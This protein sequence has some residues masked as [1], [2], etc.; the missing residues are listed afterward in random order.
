MK[1]FSLAAAVWIAAPLSAQHVSVSAVA[2]DPS[3][4]ALVW[5]CN[6]DNHSVSVVDTSVGTAVE[7]P[8]GVHP[9]SLAFDAAGTRVFVAN[10][11]GNVP[12]ERNFVTPFDG[13]EQRGTISVVDVATRSVTTTMTNVGTEPYGVAVAPAG[14][15]FAVSGFCSGTIKFYDAATLAPLHTHQFAR[16]LSFLPPGVTIAEA[17]EDRD[18][19]ADLGDPRGFVIRADGARMYVTHHKSPWISV[20]DLELDAGGLVRGTVLAAK[21]D[22]NEYGLHPI[23]APVRVQD[24][25]SQGVPRFLEDIALSPDGTRALVPHVLHNTNHDVTHDFG[26]ELAGDFANRVYPALTLIDTVRDSFGEPGDASGRLHHELADDPDPAEFVPYGGS[27]VTRAGDRVVLGG[28]GSPVLGGSAD[29]VVSGMRPGDLAFLLIGHAEREQPFGSTGVLR[30]EPRFTLPMPGGAVSVALPDVPELEGFTGFAQA[31]LV[32]ASVPERRLSNGL[33]FH[34]DRA[35]FGRGK[36]GHRAGH[37][38]RV[39]FNAA[40]DH[41]LLLNRG[42]EDVFLFRVDESDLALR[43]VFPPRSGFEERAP[44][45]TDTP[46]GDLPLGMLLVADEGTVNDDALLYVI[47][48]GTRTLSTLRVDFTAGTIEEARGQIPTLTG[49]DEMTLSERIG[50]ELFEDASRAQT[51]GNF[52]N[53]CASCHFEGGDDANVWQRDVGPRSTTAVY[54]GTLGTGLILWKGVR[55][56]MGETG[57]MFAGENGGSGI[58]TDGEQQGLVDYHE[59][60][61]FPLNPNLDPVTGAYSDA[62]AFGRDLYFGSNETG[63]NPEG[64]NAN[65]A[66]CHPDEQEDLSMFPGPRFYTTD[67]VHPDLSSGEMLGTLDPLCFSLRENFVTDSIKNVNTGVNVD[68]DGDDQPDVDRNLDGYDDRETYAAM[69]RDEKGDFRRDDPNSYEC[70]CDPDSDPDCPREDP[71]R[72]FRRAM[73]DFSIPTKLGVFSTAPYFH[74]HSAYS[75]RTLLHPDSQAFD[76]IY[77]DPAFG[78]EVVYPGLLKVFNGAH[79]IVGHED[80]VPLSSVVQ[81]TL[82]SGSPRQALMDMLAILAYIQSL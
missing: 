8:V 28:V 11:R 57:P 77:G 60:I 9:R 69:N 64:R 21:I 76:P 79:D 17:D 70:P 19:I 15:W 4:P 81:L 7:I 30:V 22:T 5:V 53:S 41:A 25:A 36:L 32:D 38:S 24:V 54:G 73:T 23:F 12:L 63:L 50:E 51:A 45:A 16:N 58:L 52:N 40:G 34:V 59:R 47:N 27:G 74:D 31:V 13:T 26:S 72:L 66:E 33:R 43:C 65:C 82:R 62:A 46:L 10:Q 3:D 67:F 14:R 39:A 37:P 78:M 18:G 2:V 35:G 20:L 44:L 49:P 6:R 71:R 55:L 1:V 48:E 29:F 75:L 61:P 42:S 68:V 80:R 56:N